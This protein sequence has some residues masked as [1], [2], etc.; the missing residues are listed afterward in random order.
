MNDKIKW[1]EPQQRF[2]FCAL[3]AIPLRKEPK[4]SAEQV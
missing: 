4:D 3:S 2:A 1:I